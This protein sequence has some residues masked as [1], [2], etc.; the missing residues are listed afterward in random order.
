MEIWSSR[1]LKGKFRYHSDLVHV[2]ENFAVRRRTPGG[3]HRKLLEKEE[4]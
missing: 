2:P 4:S 1:I 3:A